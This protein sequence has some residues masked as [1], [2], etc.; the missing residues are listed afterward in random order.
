MINGEPERLS[1]I[2]HGDHLCV[3]Y[4]HREEQIATAAAFLQDGLIAGDRCLYVANEQSIEEVRSVLVKA[5]VNVEHHA[6]RGGL[7]FLTKRESYLQSVASGAKVLIE[8]L[9]ETVQQALADGF[10]GLRVAV[11][12]AWAIEIETGD[13]LL[14]EYEALLNTFFPGTRAI[15]LCLYNR[16]QFSA[17]MIRDVLRTHPLIVLGESI[18]PN[19]YYEPPELILAAECDAERVQW[20]MVQLQ[21]RAREAAERRRLNK[22]TSRTRAEEQIRKQNERLRLL[23]EA[24]VH[25]LTADE[26]QAMMRGLFLKIAPHFGLDTYFNFMVSEAGDALRLESCTGIP[27]GSSNSITR[28]EFG[29]AICGTVAVCRQPIVASRIQELDDPKAQLVKSFGLRCYA[30]HPLLA[31]DRLLGTLSFASRTKDEFA[32]DEID[33]LRTVSHYVGAAYERL[34]LIRQLRETDRR[35]DEFLATLAHELRNPLAPVRNAV[36]ILR[37]KGPA[38]PELEWCREVIDRQMAQMTHLIDDLLDVS[39]ITRN[40]LELRKGRVHL[41]GV[42]Q[43]AIETSRPLIETMSHQLVVSLPTQP[44]LLDADVTRLAQAFS[45]LL[46]NAA[47][48]TERGGQIWLRAE[49]Q[50]SDVV[51]TVQDTGVGIPGDQLPRIFEIFAQVDRSLERSQ[52]GLG[53]GLTLVKQIVE[54][55]GGSVQARSDG[56]GKGSEFIVRLPVLIEMAPADSRATAAGYGPELADG[57]LRILVVDDNRDAA[58]SLSIMLKVMGNELRTA[59]DGEQAVATAAQFRPDV[60]LL[61]IGL[62]KLNGYETARAIRQEPWGKQMILIALTGWGQDQDRQLSQDAGFDQHLVK[63][64]DPAALTKL[65]ARLQAAKG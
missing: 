13:Q 19:V 40:K 20:M 51:V 46:H 14:I 56:A 36:Q 26:P 53:I 27:D 54:M 21:S 12:M 61:D 57:R 22:D 62:P 29:Q 64:A 50:G 16:L 7:L 37:L 39:R 25:L 5:G 63:P 3:I 52:G 42:V 59:Y 24:A 55:H 10:G 58:D 43:G 48:Y 18:C 65:L 1:E 15:A 11:E 35:K 38:A 60:I 2:R 41:E 30:C 23:S 6:N 28:L 9:R 31:G 8:A 49:R 47:K 34:W 4:D 17:P 45:N 33:F 44:V 32:P